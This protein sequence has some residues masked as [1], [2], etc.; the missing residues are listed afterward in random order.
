MGPRSPPSNCSSSVTPLTCARPFAT[1]ATSSHRGGCTLWARAPGPASCCPTWASAARPATWLRPSACRL[2][3][4]VR[5]GLRTGC[6]GP[7]I[8]LWWSTRR[9]VSAGKQGGKMIKQSFCDSERRPWN[10]ASRSLTRQDVCLDSEMM[11][12]VPFYCKKHF[13]CAH[14]RSLEVCTCHCCKCATC[15]HSYL[16]KIFK[17]LKTRIKIKRKHK[18]S[19]TVSRWENK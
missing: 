14:S 4:A 3:S 17:W 7:C 1:S 10:E 19:W 18:K 5:A 13:T 12:G 2:C 15:L 6:V 11:D 16:V 9:F 8:G